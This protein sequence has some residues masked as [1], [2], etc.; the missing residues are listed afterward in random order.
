MKTK[1]IFKRALTLLLTL[2]M[3]MSSTTLGLSAAQVDVAET[4]VDHT[5]GYVYFLKPSTWTETYVMMFIG[6]SSYTSVYTMTK[7]SNT[8]N[9][10]RYTMPSWSG[11]T[12]VAFA[13]G[14]STWGSGSWGPSNR[15]NASHYTNVYNNYGFNSGSY[16]VCVP[17]STSNNASLSINYKSSVANLNLTTMAN[18]YAADAGSTSYT[19]NAAAGTVSVSGYYMSGYSAVSTRAAVSSSSST[20]YASTTLAPGSTATFTATPNSGYTFVGWSTSSSVSDIVSTEAT[21]KYSYGISYTAKTVYAL[22]QKEEVKYSYTVSADEGG[23][24]SPTSGSATTDTGETI[25]ATANTGY[26]F[27]KWT[28]TNGRVDDASSAITTF[29]PT[30]DGATAT[31]SFKKLTYT[32]KFVDY[33]GTVLRTQTVEYGASATAPADPTRDGYNFSGWDTTYSNVTSDLTVTATYVALKY[34]NIVFSDWDGTT[35]KT[36]SILAG[37]VP[38]APADPTRE[39]YTFTGWS[40]SVTNVTDDTTYTAQYTINKYT[41]TFKGKDGASTISTQTVEHGSSA[42]APSAPDV[43][44]YTFTGWDKSYT[45]ITADTTVTALYSADTYSVTVSASTGGT[46]QTSASSVT[47]DGTVTLTATP[48]TGYSF[49]GWDITGAYE[50]VTGTESSAEFTIRPE[51]NITAKAS[52]TLDQKLTVYTYS[53]DGYTT[54][55]LTESNGTNDNIVINAVDQTNTVPF[56]GTTWTTSGEQTLTNGY[57]SS[58][59]AQLSGTVAVDPTDPSNWY[60]DGKFLVADGYRTL[61]F[62]NNYSWS[63]TISCYAWNSS[64]N[65]SWPGT[66]MKFAY[67]NNQNQAVYVALIPDSYTSVIFNNNSHQTED[68]SVSSYTAKGWYISG[69]GNGEKSRV[70]STW[71]ISTY[72]AT[73]T[74]NS[75]PI[76]LTSTLYKDGEWAGQTEVWIY[77]SGTTEIVTLRRDLLDLITDTTEEYNGGTNAKDYTAESWS[78]FVTAYEEAL[79][80]SGAAASTQKEIDD[81]YTA[82]DNAYKARELQAYF[83]VNLSQNF[84]G[85][86]IIGSTTT[87]ELSTTVQVAQ[88]KTVTLKFT[89]PTNYYIVSVKINGEDANLT[90]TNAWTYTGEYTFTEDADIE[91]VYHYNPVLSYTENVTGGTVTFT[92]TQVDTTTN[93]ISYG[94]DATLNITAPDLYYINS[95]LVNGEE[96]YNKTDESV[97]TYSGTISNITAD[98][99]VIITYAK[100]TT[101]TVTVLPYGTTGGTLYYGDTAISADNGMI[102]EVLAGETVTIT[103]SPNSGWGVYYWVVDSATG[104]RESSYTFSNISANHTI[105]V[106]WKKL[107]TITVTTSSSPASAGTATVDGNSSVTVEEYT[108]VTLVATVTDTRYKFVS[109]TVE[110]SYYATDGTSR[111]D[112]TFIIVASGDIKATANFEQVYRRIYLKDDAGWNLTDSTYIYCYG[113]STSTDVWPGY[114][115]TYDSTLGYYYADVPKDVV[116]II[117]NKGNNDDNSQVEYT[118]IGVKN[119]YT[120]GDKTNY[121]QTYVE[122]GYYLQGEWNGKS[123]SAYDLVK[124]ESNGDG[125]YSYTLTVT[126][127]TDGYIYVNPTDEKSNFWDADSSDVLTSPVTLTKGGTYASHTAVKIE[128]DTSDF[129][130]DYDVTFTFNPTTGEFSWTKVE[131][132]PTISIIGTDGRG[133]NAADANMVSANDRVGDTYFDADTV[134]SVN[135]HTYYT[136]AQVVAGNPVTFYTQVNP[137]ADGTYDYYVAGWVLNGTE[138]IYATNLGKG[139]YSGSYVFTEDSDIVPVYFHTTDWL[140]ANNVKTVTVYAVADKNITNWDKYMAA[141]T[142]YKPADVNEYEQFGPWSGQLMIPVA[143]LDGVYY[144][145]VETSAGDKIQVSGITFNN[146]PSGNNVDNSAI[147]SHSNIQTYDYYEFISLLEDGQENITFVIK[148]TNDTK[149]ADRVSTSS[150]DIANGNWDFVQYTDY[151]GLKTDIFGNNIESVD[152]TLSDSNAL[153][154]VQAGNQEVS[155]DTFTA[156]WGVKSYLYKADGT[157]IGECYSYELHDK[158]SDIWASLSAYENQRVYIS[159]ETVN[160]ARYDGEWYGDSDLSVTVNLAVNVALTTD[161]GKTYT[162]NTA[163]TVNVADYGTGYVNVSYQN[164]DVTRGTTVTLTATPKTSYKFIGWYTADGTLFT[165]NTTV[166]VT[167]AVGTT[168]TAVFEALEKG[169]FYVNHYIYQGVGTSSYIPTAHGGNA[170]LYVGIENTTKTTSAGFSVRE[171]AYIAAEEG[172]ELIITIATDATGADKFYAWYVD[173]VDKYGF[174]TFEEVGVDSADNLYNNNGTVI[175][176]NDIVYFKFKYTVKN[177]DSYSMTL[178]SDLMPIS[179][180][181]TLVYQYTDRYENIKSY[182][183]PYTLTAEEIE[184]FAGNENTAYTPAYISGDGWVN[185]VIANAP[186]VEDYFKDTTWK[187]NS[188]MYD[189]LTFLL[190]ATQPYT[191]YTVTTTVTTEDGSQVSVNQYAYNTVIDLDIRDLVPDASYYGFW[192]NDVDNNGSYNETVDIILTYGP[193]YGYRVT[194]DMTISYQAVDS[195]DDYDFNV[196]LDAPVYGREQTTDSA[197]NNKTDV[198]VIDYMINIL[199]PYFYY[200]SDFT[201]IYNGEEITDNWGKMLVTVE[202]LK[203]AGYT[204]E[205]GVI[206]EQVDTINIQSLGYEA[207]VEAAE[208]KGFGTA[209]DEALLKTVLE[210]G[211]NGWTNGSG[212]TYCTIYDASSHNI[213]NKNRVLFVLEM[214]N[215]EKN[216]NRFY[217]VYSYLTVTTPEGVKTTYISNVQTLNIYEEGT[218]DASVE[219]NTSFA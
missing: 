93:T 193:Y 132:V 86:A 90:A 101:Y 65:N 55:T 81:A 3:L 94:Y 180:N 196:S 23:T 153:Y 134:N 116:N 203:K 37:N 199:T 130:K 216:Q 163:D 186:Y 30:A 219:D 96:V 197:G 61:V 71:D 109:W 213:T 123:Y 157:Y 159:Y 40:P 118:N 112:S 69:D 85:T 62:T 84:A 97:I 53:D 11:A 155:S 151:S 140:T 176:R 110:G 102:I 104:N 131:N 99:T 169:N 108:T 166:S 158:D 160:S 114:K 126:S 170:V 57:Y 162:V 119:L 194:Q 188:A 167:A 113:G 24:V 136:E 149:N 174:T 91:V 177:G 205:Y 117:F 49:A 103:A 154:I 36:E 59:T 4:G 185:T 45:N 70:V 51:S 195:A 181:V 63:G 201:P 128:I 133:T 191:M 200:N 83:S 54:L 171:S 211:K 60:K 73:T 14:S 5:G 9:L 13:N 95:I 47:Y 98:K 7:V 27:D 175:G 206:L 137:N 78:A 26:E 77:Q 43:T 58:V 66:D 22:F 1:N 68:I 32:V 187:I 120:N 144:T 207:A 148:D 183:V 19:S 29:Y 33:D 168:Y 135:E 50:V 143:G 164:V 129:T 142:W 215:T 74:V 150:I 28:V 72:E 20:A 217:N 198:V 48:D 139:L 79:S 212:S 88:N 161:G 125:T 214:N 184:G 42:T 179:V 127:T 156:D 192:Y 64:S 15:T 124:L 172:D 190:W 39:G 107:S 82:L 152:S 25:T 173:A 2:L 75:D 31:A 44:G 189:T 16:Y 21:Y 105:S 202:S 208:A 46:A 122:A 141:Y 121:P 145:Y 106:E 146:Y 56:N 147:I 38:T 34:V 8:D 111:T 165:T 218:K 178:Y 12:Y 182:Y 204:V 52:F 17:A 210:S 100:R 67:N 89:A 209:T 18:V 92:G 76:D 10:Y 35:L 87:K 41:V 6:H 115:M 138:F 80:I